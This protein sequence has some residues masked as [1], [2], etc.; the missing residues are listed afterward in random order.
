MSEKSQPSSPDQPTE[1]LPPEVVEFHD[2]IRR[3]VEASGKTTLEAKARA[4]GVS[5]SALHRYVTD[6]SHIPTETTLRKM[7]NAAGM[8]QPEQDDFVEA[9]REA[10]AARETRQAS[11]PEFRPAQRSNGLRQT[12]E[13]SDPEPQ[14]FE[15]PDPGRQDAGQRR[16]GDRPPGFVA[17]RFRGRWRWG[18]VGVVAIVIGLTAVAVSS[19]ATPASTQVRIPSMIGKSPKQ[20]CAEL[21]SLGLSCAPND[22]EATR[23][24]DIVHSQNPAPGA[25]LPKGSPV[26]YT[27]ESSAPRPLRRYQA[28][29]KANTTFMGTDKTGPRGWHPEESPGLAYPPSTRGVPKLISIYRF[30]C[31]RQCEDAEVFRLNPRPKSGD[32]WELEGRAFRCFSPHKAPPGTRPLHRLKGEKG[33]R[34]WAIPGTPAYEAAISH[35]FQDTNND[36]LCNVW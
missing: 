9:R 33:A 34:D 36:P 22:H 4:L 10:V 17:P 19:F 14:R 15:R 25:T 24:I 35:G 26:Q 23:E 18:A 8:S 5:Q 13:R 2:R 27:F 29:D 3:L 16:G 28:P 11:A 20:A 21:R 6:P 1:G 31:T 32:G 30:R 12:G 7:L